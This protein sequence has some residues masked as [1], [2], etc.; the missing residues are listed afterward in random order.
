M[1]RFVARRIAHALAIVVLVATIAFVLLHMAPGDPFSASLENSTVPESVRQQ[2]RALY[3][4]DRPLPEQYLRWMTNVFRGDFGWSHA[5]NRPVADVLAAALPNTL[6]LMLVALSLGVALGIALG[7]LQALR[8]GGALDRVLGVTS[9]TFYSMPDFWL[10]V[11]AI[12]VVARWVPTLPTSGM[13]TPVIYTYMDPLGRAI[14]IG[15]HLFLPALVLVLLMAAGVAR[16]QRAALLDVVRQDFTRTARAKG[17]AERRVVMKHALRNALLPVIT[18]V[19]LALPALLT[20]TVFVE[21]VF[22]WPGVGALAVDAIFQRDY[23]LVMAIVVIGGF[24]VA[25]GSL[26]AD[27]LYAAADPR[28]RTA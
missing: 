25:V 22:A 6:L 5:R 18:L 3:G 9:M 26:V 16:Y 23:H 10:A 17:L 12:V 14:D 21:R 2:W 8:R 19:G 24:M 20:G 15:R 11:M 28:L 13:T 1:G 4:L 7:V 27:L